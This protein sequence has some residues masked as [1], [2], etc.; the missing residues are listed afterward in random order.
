MRIADVASV[1]SLQ[2]PAAALMST[3]ATTLSSRWRTHAKLFRDHAEEPLARAYEACATELEEAIRERDDRLLNLPEAAE[4]TGYSADH[5]GRLVRE[6][7]IPNAGRTGAPRIAHRDL[8]R[9]P[10]PVADI[11]SGCETSNAQIVQSIIKEGVG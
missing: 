10:S 6:G 11:R 3:T 2:S 9:K 4:L 8:P 7:K 5:L 1:K